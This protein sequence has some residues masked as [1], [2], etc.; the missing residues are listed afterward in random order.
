MMKSSRRGKWVRE[1]R[2]FEM[3]EMKALRER[4]EP[5]GGSRRNGKRTAARVRRDR[6]GKWGEG[7]C[8]RRKLSE[9]AWKG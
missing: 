1:A 6:L 3:A 4:S 7:R 2:G 9:S 5:A 8:G